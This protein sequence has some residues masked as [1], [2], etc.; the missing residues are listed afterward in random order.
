MVSPER[1]MA[2]VDAV[3]HVV[4][5]DVPGALVECGVWRGGSVLGMIRTLQRL[6]VSDRD[7]YLCDTFTGM[8][9]PSAED[10]SAFDPPASATFEAA[11]ASGGRAWSGLF[12][13]DVFGLEQVRG[14]IEGSG[15][16]S[17]RVHFVVGDVL[18]TIP[19]GV[20]GTIAVLRLDTDW[21][22]STRHELEH[23]Y[24]RLARARS[25][26]STTTATG[27][28][29]R[30]PS[31]TTSLQGT[32]GRCCRGPTTRVGWGSRSER[33]RR[34]DPEHQAVL[35]AGFL[36][37]EPV[38]QLDQHLEQDDERGAKSSRGP[39]SEAGLQEL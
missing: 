17:E 32:T 39:E 1:L 14:A 37:R 27:R 26:S 18:E 7:V 6:G 25:S 16:P 29:P 5:R 34:P 31:M 33:F 15:Y 22:D 36:G 4:R 21:Y 8:T 9:A 13:E 19:G 30:R 38:G 10:L 24:P 35:A 3:E 28:A 20:P 12:G 2:T 23:L 11:N